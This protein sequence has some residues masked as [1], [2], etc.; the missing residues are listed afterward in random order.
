M[1]HVMLLLHI[2]IIIIYIRARSIT[3]GGTE[4]NQGKNVLPR[5]KKRIKC[6]SYVPTS[7]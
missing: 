1:N 5:K 7:H 3:I 4:I 6:V 2:D